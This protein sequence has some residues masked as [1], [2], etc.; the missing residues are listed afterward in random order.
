M[1]DDSQ[2]QEIFGWHHRRE[3]FASSYLKTLFSGVILSTTVISPHKTGLT[4]FFLNDLLP[5]AVDEGHCVIYVDLSDTSFPATAAFLIGLEKA[6]HGNS[7][8]LGV[9]FNFFKGLF[10]PS[11]PNK[12][13]S[14]LSKGALSIVDQAYFDENFDEHIEIFDTKI[15]K[16]AEKSPV[17]IIVDHAQNLRLNKIGVKFANYFKDLLICNRFAIKPIY[18]MQTLD[19][20]ANVFKDPKFPLYSEGASVHTLPPLDRAFVRTVMNKVGAT[21]HLDEAMHCFSMVKNQPGI[22]IA[23]IIAWDDK[24]GKSLSSHFVSALEDKTLKEEFVRT[25]ANI[26]AISI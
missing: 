14:Y 26:K 1:I 22:F 10:S 17:L 20:W 3:V 21:V 24:S 5:H 12:N 7:R 25:V 9:S 15:K 18:G 19:A 11:K 6:M 4:S 8:N 2:Q 23:I 13:N 16:I